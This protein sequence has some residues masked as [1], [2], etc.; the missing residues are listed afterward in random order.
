MSIGNNTGSWKRLNIEFHWQVRLR[1]SV[2]KSKYTFWRVYSSYIWTFL[3]YFIKQQSFIP[4][5]SLE[6]I[7][8]LQSPLWSTS[9]VA[10]NYWLVYQTSGLQWSYNWRWRQSCIDW[11]RLYW[12][13]RA[14]QVTEQ[15]EKKNKKWR[16]KQKNI[17]Q[18]KPASKGAL[19]YNLLVLVCWKC[20]WSRSMFRLFACYCC[21]TCFLGSGITHF[22]QI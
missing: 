19:K 17:D 15:M 18:N 2:F 21:W 20:R 14:E 12:S 8:W 22:P 10:H 13:L 9:G 1:I 7:R 3:S 16:I 5:L 6:G 4:I 11:M